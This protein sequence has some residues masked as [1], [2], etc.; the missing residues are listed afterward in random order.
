M[1]LI[2]TIKA[3]QSVQS[4]SSEIQDECLVIGELLGVQVVLSAD[5][6]EL[7]RRLDEVATRAATAA[8]ASRE[9]A[10]DEHPQEH[11]EPLIDYSLGNIDYASAHHD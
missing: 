3:V 11:S 1:D 4:F 5:N 10:R 9:A 8:T 6:I 2:L 7:L